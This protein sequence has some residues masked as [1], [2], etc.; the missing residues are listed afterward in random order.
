MNH[1]IHFFKKIPRPGWWYTLAIPELRRLKQEDLE[2][3]STL[4]SC[5][6]KKKRVNP[7]RLCTI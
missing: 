4:R 3:E 1:H 7:Q 2:F 6:K 5:L